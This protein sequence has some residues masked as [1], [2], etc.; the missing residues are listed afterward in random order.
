VP[1]AGW[2]SNA[3]QEPEFIVQNLNSLSVADPQS[4]AP[5]P[6]D[7][8]RIMQPAQLHGLGHL[9]THPRTAR[10]GGLDQP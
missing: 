3:D 7:R 6:V 10:D 4:P 1:F 8:G 2:S 5:A 9:G